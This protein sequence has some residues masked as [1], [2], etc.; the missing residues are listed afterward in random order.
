MTVTA[1]LLFIKGN[2]WWGKEES[3]ASPLIKVELYIILLSYFLDWLQ[4][5][6]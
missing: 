1:C 4:T 3:D 5:V 2:P 6:I